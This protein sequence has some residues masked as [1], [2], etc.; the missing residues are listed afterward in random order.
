MTSLIKSVLNKEI[1]DANE[2]PKEVIDKIILSSDGSAGQALK[3]LDSVIDM[4]DLSQAIVMIDNSVKEEASI[5]DVCRLLANQ[6]KSGESKWKALQTL[7]TNIDTEPEVIRKAVLTY[8]GKVMLNNSSS[9][10]SETIKLFSSSFM[11]SYKA[12]LINACYMTCKLHVN[13][14]RRT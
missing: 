10:I 6:N 14:N 1:E 8:L 11:Y 3:L 2:F 5:I 12:G 4:E 13:L 7:L 9:I